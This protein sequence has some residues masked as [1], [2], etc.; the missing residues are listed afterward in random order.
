MLVIRT[1]LEKKGYDVTCASNGHEAIDALSTHDS[2]RIVLMD[3]SMPG[4]DGC[5]A[6]R[7]I[8]AGEAGTAVKDIPIIALTAHSIKGAREEFLAAGMNDYISKPFDQDDV[9]EKI[10]SQLSK[11]LT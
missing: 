4:M 11:E 5:T 3:V 8:R 9:F 6:T 10:Q 2:I 1:L 7:K